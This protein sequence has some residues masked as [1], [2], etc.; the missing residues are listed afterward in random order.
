MTREELANTFMESIAI[1]FDE[2]ADGADVKG[3]RDR[4]VK[5]LEERENGAEVRRPDGLDSALER[6]H[7]LPGA[8]QLIRDY[9]DSLECMVVAQAALDCGWGDCTQGAVGFRF[10]AGT[11][12]NGPLRH[13]WL[14]VC[15]SHVDDKTVP[16]SAH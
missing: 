1:M 9:I 4:L 12:L 5:L 8:Q 16:I 13:G 10:D 6:I 7:I 11:D 3:A 15:L 14:P 2:R